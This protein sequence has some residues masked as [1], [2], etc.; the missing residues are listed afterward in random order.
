MIYIYIY[1]SHNFTVILSVFFRFRQCSKKIYRLKSTMSIILQHLHKNQFFHNVAIST[2]TTKKE[3]P[4][5]KELMYV[6]FVCLT[7]QT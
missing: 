2:V 1:I 4:A 5:G 6:I 7:K 3:S